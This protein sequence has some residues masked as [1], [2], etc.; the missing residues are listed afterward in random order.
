MSYD[1]QLSNGDIVVDHQGDVIILEGYDKL[2][3]D[4]QR[5]IN[6]SRGDNKFDVYEGCGVVDLLGKALPR[7]LAEMILN[8][9][10][11]FGI[12]H[13]IDQQNT[14]RLIQTL[15]VYEQIATL[16]ALVI[17]QIE[18]KAIEFEIVLTT[19]RGLQI[20]FAASVK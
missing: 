20:A 10:V 18:L 11:Y 13:M 5:L 14:Q 15:S 1:L 19:V 17:K 16:D 2:N 9:D 6:T 8:K 12:Q 3:Q 4:L 7:D